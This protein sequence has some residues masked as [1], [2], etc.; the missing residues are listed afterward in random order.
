M[1]H[2]FIKFREDSKI[3]GLDF[4]KNI[5]VKTK[6]VPTIIEYYS[7]VDGVQKHGPGR[8]YGLI[9][10]LPAFQLSPTTKSPKI[11]K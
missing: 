10:S 7:L 1:L 8:D 9:E 11:N 4:R 5:Q 6:L 3:K 2:T